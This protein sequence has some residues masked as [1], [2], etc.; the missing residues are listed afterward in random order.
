MHLVAESDLAPAKKAYPA[1][2]VD[3]RAALVLNDAG[4]SAKEDQ[5]LKGY[6]R[7]YVND[8]FA[9]PWNSCSRNG[10]SEDRLVCRQARQCQQGAGR[11]GSKKTRDLLSC[12]VSFC[13]PIGHAMPLMADHRHARINPINSGWDSAEPRHGAYTYLDTRRAGSSRP[14]EG[15]RRK[16]D[17]TLHGVV[18]YFPL[19]MP[20]DVRFGMRAAV[21]PHAL[22]AVT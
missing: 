16:S 8:S 4:F 1:S 20:T 5:P 11:D 22:A 9:N 7:R 12:M 2:I 18:S 15:C 21:M 14:P 3:D 6:E 17:K 13:R 10:S 19:A